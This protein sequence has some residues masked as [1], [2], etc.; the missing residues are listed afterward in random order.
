MACM[1]DTTIEMIEP[2]PKLES[3]HCRIYAWLL[4]LLLRSATPFSGLLFWYW[5]DYFYGAV[6][7]LV[8]YM[9][10]GIIRSK[11]RNSVIPLSQQEYSYSDQ[12]IAS[13][14]VAKRLCPTL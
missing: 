13:W 14:Y 5:Y 3:R 7:L 6:A 4:T 9:V 2:T 12:A 8:A 1:N 11:L 10:M